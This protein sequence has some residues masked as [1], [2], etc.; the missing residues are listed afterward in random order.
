MKLIHHCS[1]GQPAHIGINYE[2]SMA[3]RPRIRFVI[4]AFGKYREL[5]VRIRPKYRSGMKLHVFLNFR[6]WYVSLQ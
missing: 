2:W 4:W 6:S 5:Y 1:E 3:S